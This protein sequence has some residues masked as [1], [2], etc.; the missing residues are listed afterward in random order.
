MA[1][2]ATKK[3]ATTKPKT[4]K[5]SEEKE[6][7]DQT[8]ALKYKQ[9]VILAWHCNGEVMDGKRISRK[10][11]AEILDV[12]EYRLLKL[13]ESVKNLFSKMFDTQGKAKE[14]FYSIV[15][16]LLYQL[17]EDRAR[18]VIH[19][20]HLDKHIRIVSEKI[21]GVWEWSEGSADERN[22]KAKNLRSLM[23]YLRHLNAQRTESIKTLSQTSQATNN[24]LSLFC[25]KGESRIPM[26]DIDP[27]DENLKYLDFRGAIKIIQDNVPSVL[28]TQSGHNFGKG[29]SN[30]NEGFEELEVLKENKQIN[31]N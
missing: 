11:L 10:Q 24:F 30:P 14:Q 8:L 5:A 26:D 22:L 21:E 1:R 28:P 17:R 20:D 4:K 29:N 13:I 19:I 15:G 25:K 3:K 7:I 18:A 27:A 23:N 9:E 16:T 12:S 6:S 31:L 2:K